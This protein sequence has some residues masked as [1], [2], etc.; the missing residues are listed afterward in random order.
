MS[1]QALSTTPPPLE[2]SLADWWALAEDEPGELVDGF[3]EEEE[4][5]D[6]VHE[7]LVSWL[8]HFFHGHVSRRGG[9]VV[10]S[11][12]K[13][14]VAPDRGRKPDL[15]VY[16]PGRPRPTA[17]GPIDVPPD[18]AVEV[19][20]PSPRDGRRD[21]VE[22]V[23]EYAAFGIRYY[24]IVDPQLRSLEIL[25]LGPEGFYVHL[26]GVSRGVVEEVPGCEGLRLDVD[27]L[28]AEIDRVEA[29]S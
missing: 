4:M 25:E 27:A 26:L 19:V 2:L 10:G 5:P 7:I 14:A 13:L 8:V 20:S 6:F 21:R 15:A 3:L 17:R 9:F 23:A 1:Q 11:E 28:W 16:L 29:E 24:W 18:V 12:T 22:K